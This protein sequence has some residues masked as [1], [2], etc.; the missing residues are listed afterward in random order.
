LSDG[1]IWYWEFFICLILETGG[2]MRVERGGTEARERG[3]E[4]MSD[5]SE[6]LS[7]CFS[8]AGTRSYLNSQLSFSTILVKKKK[9]TKGILGGEERR[10]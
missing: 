7:A 2:Q 4:E 9:I 5:S 10:H 1:A 3:E 6:R 8:G